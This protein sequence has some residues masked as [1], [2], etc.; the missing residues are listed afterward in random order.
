MGQD[1]AIL[2]LV[3]PGSV[4]GKGRT[5]LNAMHILD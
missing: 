4:E 5:S 3:V 2:V 1:F